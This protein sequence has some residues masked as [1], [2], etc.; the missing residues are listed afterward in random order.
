M[1]WKRRGGSPCPPELTGGDGTPPL[2]HLKVDVDIKTL[3][4][5][6]VDIIFKV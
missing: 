5:Y 4:F 2:Q 1:R 3:L 6:T